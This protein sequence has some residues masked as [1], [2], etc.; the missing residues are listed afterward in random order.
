VT[1]DEDEAAAAVIVEGEAAVRNLAT[2]HERL[3]PCFARTKPFAQARKYVSG[4]I[5]DLPRKNAW[6]LAEH[7]GDPTPDRMQRLLNHAVW[8]HEQAMR[9]VR[10]YV[11]EHLADQPLV[12]AALDES[13]Q[14]KT[15]QATIGTQRQYMGCAGRIANGVNT[16]YCSYATPGGHALVDARIYVPADQL[17]DPQ[18]RA[19]CG[20][21]DDLAFRTKPQLAIDIC[22]DM[23]TDHTMPPWVAG[24]EVYGRS[25]QLR[26]FLQDNGVGYVMRVGCAFHVDV[27]AELT[28]RADTVVARFVGPDAWQVCSVAGSKGERRY[29]WAWIATTSSQHYLLIRRHLI[30]NELAFHFCYVPEDR[31]VTVMTLVRVACLRW[32]VEEGFEF[33]KDHFGLD[34]SQVRLYTALS[35]HIVLTIAALA[36]CAVTAAQAKTTASAEILPTTPDEQPP[37]DPGLIALTVAEVKRLFMLVTRQQLP[38]AHHLRWVWWRRR[39]QARARW[40]HHRARLRRQTVTA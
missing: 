10:G 37:A 29:A 12:V 2:L 31:P 7:A 23:V 16:V 36:V 34:H 27:S 24:D 28:A 19:A 40:F 11:A 38:Q 20:I 15:G 22:R 3:A 33:G 30:T 25:S 13:G 32:P 9:T 1:Q 26:Q 5:S 17:A 4:L 18:R 14:E 21:G 35:R 6:T 8:D 39:H